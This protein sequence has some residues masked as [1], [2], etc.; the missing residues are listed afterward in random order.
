M[1]TQD[2]RPEQDLETAKDVFLT[3][4][5]ILAVE[6][7]ADAAFNISCRIGD[8]MMINPVTSPTLVTKENIR[9][10]TL[11]EIPAMGQLHPAM[12]R[13]RPD[14]GGVVH[15]HPFYCVAFSTL[16]QEFKPIHHYGSLFF[17]KQLVVHHS[18][19]QVKTKTR[20]EEI[21]ACLGKGRAILQQGHGATVVGKDL[22][23][24]LLGAIYLEES[25]RMNYV[26]RQMGKPEPLSEELATKI[27]GQI[28]KQRSQD[29]AWN[30]YVD[31]VRIQTGWTGHSI[32]RKD[33][34]G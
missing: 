2:A 5:R 19:G 9:V 25:M 26:A 8:R 30:H 32:D 10:H 13:A 7:L 11:D 3:A 15:V 20:G 4:C 6:G 27:T 16:G 21:A 17:G 34:F 31:K 33:I 23:E 12:Y 29:K 28:F 24:A 22:Q 14:I 18:P 1:D